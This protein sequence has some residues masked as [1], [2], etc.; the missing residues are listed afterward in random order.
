MVLPV[1]N[2]VKV[3]DGSTLS[4]NTFNACQGHRRCKQKAPEMQ[5]NSS[6]NEGT[7]IFSWLSSKSDHPK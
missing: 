1:E 4:A 3:Q 7:A 2:K 6:T 5:G